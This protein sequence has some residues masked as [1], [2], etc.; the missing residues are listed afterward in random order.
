MGEQLF[1]REELAHARTIAAG[2]N[3]EETSG[4]E[5]MILLP[6]AQSTAFVDP[7]AAASILNRYRSAK[8]S[9][10]LHIQLSADP[11]VQAPESYT[12]GVI[13]MSVGSVGEAQD[14]LSQS[15]ALWREAGCSW[16]ASEAAVRLLE[17]GSGDAEQRAY[18][19][20]H[21]PKFPNSWIAAR[22]KVL[23]ND[24]LETRDGQACKAV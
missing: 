22:A 6:L 11:L 17:I 16:R 7:S 3:W 12:A 19:A 20:E 10:P 1:A 21:A 18:L 23:L 24:S 4:Q 8:P 13:A 9:M 5:R 2:V 15:F 14:L